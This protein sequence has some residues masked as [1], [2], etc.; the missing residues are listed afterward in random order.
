M[1]SNGDKCEY[2]PP[3]IPDGNQVQIERGQHVNINE[4]G[5]VTIGAA[6]MPNQYRAELNGVVRPAGDQQFVWEADFYNMFWDSDRS[7]MLYFVVE[8]FGR[9]LGSKSK[10]LIG[11]SVVEIVNPEDGKIKYN[12]YEEK[13]LAGP[14]ITFD[15]NKMKN[16]VQRG[17]VIGFTLLDPLVHGMPPPPG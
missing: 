3:G 12:F 8:V 11:Y 2:Q 13:L 10:A 7:E 14:D 15:K 1:Q 4:I 5:L 17:E 6:T 16:K 9:S